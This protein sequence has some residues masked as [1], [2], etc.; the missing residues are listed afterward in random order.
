M[1]NKKFRFVNLGY[2]HFEMIDVED[3]HN[4]IGGNFKW[5]NNHN[6]FA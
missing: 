5:I 2:M 4:I 3:K 6:Y 1:I